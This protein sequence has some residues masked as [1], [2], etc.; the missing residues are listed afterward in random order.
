MKLVQSKKDSFSLV[1]AI[2]FLVLGV[3]LISNPGGVVKF[4]TYIIGIILMLLGIAKLI[5]YL[6]NKENQFI[7]NTNNLTLGI[8]LIV[9]GIVVMFCSSAIEFIIRIIMGG[10][11]IYSGITK[12]ILCINLKQNNITTWYIPLVS[13]VIML[14]CG[15]YTVVKTNVIGVAGGIVLVIYAV[16][17]IIQYVV[18]PKDKNPDIIKK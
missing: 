7:N 2:L 4:I 13:A 8:I 10:W 1:A 15:L 11:L 6:K 12:L 18:V 17:E 9:I 14:A 5:S 3:I 16:A